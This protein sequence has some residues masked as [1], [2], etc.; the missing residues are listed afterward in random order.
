MMEVSGEN[1]VVQDVLLKDE[2]LWKK[3][4]KKWFWLYFFSF[5]IAPA[6]Y[7]IKVLVSN[8]VSVA[9]VWIL[10]SI[11]GLITFL[12][13]YNDLG[14]TESLQYFLPRFWLKKQ[15]NYIKTALYLSLFVQVFTAWIIALVLWRGAPW[16]A[17][18]YFH[19]PSAMIIL[20][21]FCFYFLGINLFQIL[22]SVFYAFQNTFAL[23][24][25]EF[26]RMWSLV[27]FTFF[28]FLTDRQ[29]IEWYSLNWVLWLWIWILVGGFLFYR[30]YKKPLLQWKLVWE[31]SMIREYVRYALRC[32]VGLNAGT[33]FGQ[34]I[35]QMIIVILGPES[36]GY[37]TNFLS[38]FGISSTIV[39]P[40]LWLIFPIV[41]ELVTK[42]NTVTLALL[43][44]FF[45]T[46]FSLFSLFLIVFFVVFGSELALVFFGEKFLFSGELFRWGAGLTLFT[47]FVGF[48]FS[49]L[50]GM[51]KIKDR[52][53]ILLFSLL[54][55]ALVAWVW[56]NLMGIYG[57]ILAMG[58][59]YLMLFIM[60]FW[61]ILRDVK[62][63][64]EW[65]FVLRNCILL[66][67][68]WV[69]L[70]FLKENLFV[71]DDAFRTQNLFRLV[72]VWF[73]F[74]F[75]FVG[76]NWKRAMMLRDEIKK[77]RGA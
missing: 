68:M 50:A 24:F 43:Y 71:F 44:R 30:Q 70:W 9:D 39:W 61:L 59:W 26:V 75:A 11:V 29:S 16:L 21:Y 41:S 55:V 32:F 73:G 54:V 6:W 34:V 66:S 47:T 52:V 19:S 17:E 10:Y 31:K 65:L 46:Y 49:V 42:K 45:Y 72:V 23:Q 51:G 60:S 28:F 38:L 76:L 37:Y 18:H 77:I 35:Q 1:I 4:I 2:A 27:G 62:F 5:L 3:L 64:F 25:V 36:A 56:L 40:I 63:G 13:V 8:S 53:K 33:L 14:L 15:Y 48:N 69:G 67:V 7:V 58:V 74:F 20:K 22:Q 12:N 57:A